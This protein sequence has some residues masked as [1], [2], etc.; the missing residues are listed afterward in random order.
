MQKL[1]A[2]L[3]S[4]TSSDCESDKS[5]NDDDDDDVEDGFTKNYLGNLEQ[6]LGN[7]GLTFTHDDHTSVSE[8]VNSFLGNYFL[9]ILV[10]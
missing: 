2:D 5:S 7:I 10:E 6:S 9:E 3:L 4:G 1:Y 8:V